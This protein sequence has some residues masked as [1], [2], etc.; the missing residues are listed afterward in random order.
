M[1]VL[2]NLAVNRRGLIA[3][4]PSTHTITATAAS[5]SIVDT[6]WQQHW[7]RALLSNAAAAVAELDT[8]AMDPRPQ[9]LF[10]SIELCA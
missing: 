4:A 6:S 9:P 8:V 7:C 1:S 5:G 10:P 3:E 2:R